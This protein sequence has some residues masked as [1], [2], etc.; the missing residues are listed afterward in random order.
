MRE[1]LKYIYTGK[2]K[3]DIS[4]LM[5]ILKIASFFGLENLIDSCRKYLVSGY[6]N[7][8][9]LCILYCEVRDESQ[10]F[11][12]MKSFLTSIIPDKIEIDIICR[13]LREIYISRSVS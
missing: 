4:N 13:V 11:D 6:L 1:F 5:G 2:L 12:E 9:D 10:D 3:I 7:A 8:F